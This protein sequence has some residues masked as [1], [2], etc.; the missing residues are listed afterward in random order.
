MKLRLVYDVMSYDGKR[1]MDCYT[2]KQKALHL[3]NDN[4]LLE[5]IIV[6]RMVPF[7]QWLF[8]KIVLR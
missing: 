2:T 5:L 1:C 4:R 8:L 6:E 7:R 3:V